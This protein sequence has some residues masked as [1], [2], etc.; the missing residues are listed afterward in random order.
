M[1]R[2]AHFAVPHPSNGAKLSERGVPQLLASCACAIAGFVAVFTM[3]EMLTGMALMPFVIACAVVVALFAACALLGRV[4]M[5][6]EKAFCAS[7][8]KLIAEQVSKALDGSVPV[9]VETWICDK[10]MAS[11]SFG[12]DTFGYVGENGNPSYIARFMDASVGDVGEIEVEVFS[13]EKVVDS[14]SGAHVQ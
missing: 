1:R 9:E 12:C 2:I 3:Y 6:K 11:M 7:S 4:F 10:L 13:D 5:K 14:T 8:S